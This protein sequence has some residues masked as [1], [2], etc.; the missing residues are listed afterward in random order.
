MEYGKTTT[1][2]TIIKPDQQAITI[3]ASDVRNYLCPKAS[4]QEITLFLK[5]CQTEALN[6]FAR[7][8]Y[9]IKY[10]EK[11]P[12]AIVI[13]IDA[14]LKAA[15]MN[16]KYDGHEAGIILNKPQGLEFREGSFT[17]ENEE[18]DLAGGWAKVY[19]TDKKRPFYSAVNIKEYQKFTTDW[20]TGERRPSRF[21]NE[22]PATMIRKVALEHAFRE[23]FPNRFANITTT[24]EWTEVTEGE[25]PE[26]FTRDGPDWTKFW[27]KLGERGITDIQ[28]HALLQVGSIKKDWVDQGK[29]LE[30]AFDLIVKRAEEAE[31]RELA[32]ESPVGAAAPS[33]TTKQPQ[34]P[35]KTKRRRDPS[36]VKT[37][38]QLMTACWEDFNL[39]PPAVLAELN[40]HSTM[41]ITSPPDAY[42]AIAGVRQ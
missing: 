7:E 15:E 4:V 17:L 37:I 42:Q 16:D 30:E 39:A 36:S 21:W 27:T 22:M 41:D 12:A 2:V 11:S 35:A 38:D 26:A 5:T 23:A 9:L 25:L 24:A 28:A 1:A 10:D 18:G 29:T 19:R 20:K 32:S 8:I 14:F 40:L 33:E 13:S 31:W 34:A 3:T 6:P